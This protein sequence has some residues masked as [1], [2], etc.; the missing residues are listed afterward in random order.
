MK[1]IIGTALVAIAA[2]A[3][4]AGCGSSDSDSSSDPTTTTA[5]V[6]TGSD[7][8][9]GGAAVVKVEGKDL[10][11]LDL[12]SVTCVKQGDG[13]AI[14]SG[15][16]GGQEGVSATMKDGN[17]PTVTALAVV[18]DGSTLAVAPGVGSAEVAVDGDKYTIT[19]T[20]TGADLKD[21]AAGPVSK[22]FEIVITCK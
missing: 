1:R 6:E 3:V 10:E 2:A 5:G 4:L 21:L 7:A 13:I 22:K 15:T 17:P 20:A 8:S 16:I 18:V 14:A 11:G 9:T 12:K 19:G